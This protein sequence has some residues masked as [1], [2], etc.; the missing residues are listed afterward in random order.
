MFKIIR[1]IEINGEEKF[2]CDFP[3]LEQENFLNEQYLEGWEF[4]TTISQGARF[5]F[6]QRI[7]M[8]MST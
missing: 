4:V 5:V 1:T 3:P 7:D 8:R 6:K 2:I